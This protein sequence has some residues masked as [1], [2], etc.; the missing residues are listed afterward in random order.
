[1]KISKP[2][3]FINNNLSNFSS[4]SIES[5]EIIETSFQTSSATL[6]I[7]YCLA[8]NP[9]KQENLR[10]ELLS[11]LP[12]KNSP[13]TVDKMKNMPYLRAVIKEG[14]RMYPPTVGNVRESTKDL[15][16]SG[17]HVPAGLNVGM[18]S[19]LE[20]F[21]K[22]HYPNPNEFI[23]ERWL[24][25]SKENAKG[26]PFSYLPFG[27]GARA[28]IGKRLADLEMEILVSNIIR[29]FKLGWNYPDMKVKSVLVNIP[30]SEMKFKVND[31]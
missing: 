7:L 2:I 1:M 31:V 30:D 15:V 16:L 17:Y 23:P 26:N 29:N 5:V 21:N 3:C 22:L 18:I 24:K 20:H 11:V 27:F 10:N 6:S 9:E 19:M 28:C 12:D 13:L 4:F 14:I 25:N 8:K